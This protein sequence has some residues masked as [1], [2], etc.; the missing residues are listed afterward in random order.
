MQNRRIDV[1]MIKLISRTIGLGT[2]ES[3]VVCRAVVSSVERADNQ[4]A[5]APP[6]HFT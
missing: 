5:S 4:L 6:P 3:L 2:S 1:K